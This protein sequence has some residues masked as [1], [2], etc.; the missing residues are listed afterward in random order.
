MAW[1]AWV[2]LGFSSLWR[3]HTRPRFPQGYQ[4]ITITS[5]SLLRGRSLLGLEKGAYEHLPAAF[6]CWHLQPLPISHLLLVAV[7]VDCWS[8]GGNT[9]SGLDGH[10]RKRDHWGGQGKQR[11]VTNRKLNL[12][13]K[14]HGIQSFTAHTV[15][16]LLLLLSQIRMQS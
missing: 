3:A 16:A 4:D 9:N 11:A 12:V 10:A 13:P 8:H 1:D 5:P 15:V 6:V 14:C 2:P 7:C